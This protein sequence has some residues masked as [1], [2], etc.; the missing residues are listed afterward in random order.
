MFASIAMV[1][2][3][4]RAALIAFLACAAV[5]SSM[6]QPSQDP[7]SVV[8]WLGH[9]QG[10]VSFSPAG[11]DTWAYAT[12]NR[13]LTTGDQL[14]VERGGRAELHVGSTALRL[15]H[16]SELSFTA[17][18]DDDMRW[19]LSRGSLQ[20][21]IRAIDP[22]QRIEVNAPHLAFVPTSPGSYRID[23]DPDSGATR[24]TTWSGEGRVY[25][26]NGISETIPARASVVYGVKKK[27]R[28]RCRMPSTAGRR[29]VTTRNPGRPRPGMCPAR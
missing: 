23:V 1:A 20:L 2:M 13:P 11:T 4:I 19:R 12:P 8:A 17:L 22:G 9:T 25:G 21:R 29:P 26:D 14:W 18:D 16:E 28:T 7:P 15:G 27:A 10:D 3:M 6:A 5:S 24:V